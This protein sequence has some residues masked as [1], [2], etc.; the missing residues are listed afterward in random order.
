MP[1]AP[2]LL[3]DLA[4]SCS[5]GVLS[6]AIS[7]MFSLI[8]VQAVHKLHNWGCF[9]LISRSA[10]V[11]LMGNSLQ[12]SPLLVRKAGGGGK[13]GLNTTQTVG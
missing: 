13:M 5:C 8:E 4:H 11:L 6:S 1:F 10:R 3:A 9:S 2:A 12:N 7:G